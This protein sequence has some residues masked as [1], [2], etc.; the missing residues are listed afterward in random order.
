MKQRSVLIVGVG[1]E[2]QML[3]VA[4]SMLAA[5]DESITISP[6]E[7][8]DEGV[9]DI[10]FKMYHKE[11]FD[12]PPPAPRGSRFIPGNDPTPWKRRRK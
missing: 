3:F 2:R 11:A 10:P 4:M 12:Y 8:K 1:G 9:L 7:P 5:R 6:R